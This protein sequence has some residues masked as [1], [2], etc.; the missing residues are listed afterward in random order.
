[1]ATTPMSG[2]ETVILTLKILGYVG[3]VGL[4]LWLLQKYVVV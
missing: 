2:P 1:M 4:V 3:L